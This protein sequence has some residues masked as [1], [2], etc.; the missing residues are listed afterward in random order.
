MKRSRCDQ[1]FEESTMDEHYH[2]LPIDIWAIIVRAD[3]DQYYNYCESDLTHANYHILRFVSKTWHNLIH[4]LASRYGHAWGL[5]ESFRSELDTPGMVLVTWAFDTWG[6]R[7]FPNAKKIYGVITSIES[8]LWAEKRWGHK[9]MDYTE[10][11]WTV[12]CR[13]GRLNILN[14]LYEMEFKKDNSTA[15]IVKPTCGSIET[16]IPVQNAI[17]DFFE[18]FFSED[19]E[20]VEYRA[21]AKWLLEKFDL[22]DDIIKKCRLVLLY[23]ENNV[24]E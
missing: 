8:F 22:C 6:H 15:D 18:T 16:P 20:D 23:C 4:Y 14:V 2:G 1:D 11:V 9:F 19:T 17:E 10:H 24:N 13:Y 5:C 21:T 3:C 7:A 12:A